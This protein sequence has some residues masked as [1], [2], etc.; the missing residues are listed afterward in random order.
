VLNY[1]YTLLKYFLGFQCYKAKSDE[2]FKRWIDRE[3]EE[4]KRLRKVKI[5]SGEKK[6]IF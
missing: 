3:I 1:I 5:F 6:S 2:E 4:K